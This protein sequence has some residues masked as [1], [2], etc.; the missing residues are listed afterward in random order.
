MEYH[1]F[2]RQISLTYNHVW[3]KTFGW[4]AGTSNI[5]NA[6][7]SLTYNHI[8]FK[9]SRWKIDTKNIW[10]TRI[11]FSFQSWS[12]K[13]HTSKK[14]CHISMNVVYI[15]RFQHQ[16]WYWSNLFSNH[17]QRWKMQYHRSSSTNA[18]DLIKENNL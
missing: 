3:F 7:I 4:K 17:L 13:T 10:N 8:S 18:K 16:I 1:T 2:G 9:T 12:I 14:N 6:R 15:L 11:S 5:W